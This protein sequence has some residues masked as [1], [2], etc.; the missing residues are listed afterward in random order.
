MPEG[1]IETPG[2][3]QRVGGGPGPPVVFQRARKIIAE[4]GTEMDQFG[5][6]SR[7]AK[8]AGLAPGSDESAGKIH[9]RH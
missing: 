2:P 7:V 6:D 3:L 9:S 1:Q 4:L 5:K 8:W